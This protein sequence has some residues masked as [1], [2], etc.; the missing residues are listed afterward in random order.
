MTP[1][2]WL[3]Y[4]FFTD[5]ERKNRER[6]LLF[7]RWGGLG[8]HRY[9]IGFSGDAI[10]V[11]ESLAF[12]PYFTA[13]ASNVGFGYWSHDIG[14][15]MP[16]NVDGEL[17][18]RW[19]QFGAF[20]PIL[21]TH[22]TKNPEAERR[23]WLYPNQY[24]TAMR[25]AILQRYAMIPYVYT[26]AR[27]AYDTG[28]S[29]C[30]PMYYEHPIEEDAYGFKDQYYFGDD[31]IVAPVA[32]PVSADTMVAMKE[33]W[34]P[35]GEWVEWYTGARL[36]GPGRFRRS[37]AIDEIPVFV[38]AGAIIPMQ[39]QMRY[40][41]EKPVDPLILTI[42][43]GESGRAR[44]YE[45]QGNSLGYQKEECAWTSVRQ[46]RTPTGSTLVEIDPVVGTFPGRPAA[47]SY[48]L[49]LVGYWPPASVKCNGR[50]IPRTLVGEG[51]G[52]QYDGEQGTVVIP[53]PRI[54]LSKKV[55][56]IVDGAKGDS[57]ARGPIGIRGLT[58]RLRRVMNLLNS[59]WSKEWS[60]ELLVSA[61]QTG[62]RMSLDPRRA[63]HEYALLLRSLPAISDKLPSLVIADSVRTRAR[64]HL[65]TLQM[66]VK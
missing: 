55:T 47:R 35:A 17:Y 8:N 19:I 64:E 42:F 45:D 29:I 27:K 66:L 34:L 58:N 28:V 50:E 62:N 14:G 46:S 9:Q 44:V 59:Q 5:M 65:A 53:I 16:G 26:A 23:I 24:F 61:V 48:E 40:T 1:T 13:T 43:E 36:C 52:W 63:K 25:D 30:R 2:W 7:H 39:P 18:T 49:R 33:V 57:S 11:W 22:T 38:R 60:P 4:V 6:P 56:V 51:A 54:A 41:G 10:S 37:F 15:H 31:M 12:Q 32:T 3:N 20:S 21:R